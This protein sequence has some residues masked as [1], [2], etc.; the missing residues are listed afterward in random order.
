MKYVRRVASMHTKGSII[1]RRREKYY[2]V[3]A[4]LFCV[5][6][7]ND[8][9][10]WGVLNNDFE[11]DWVYALEG[12]GTDLKVFHEVTAVMLYDEYFDISIDLGQKWSSLTFSGSG[13]S[14][15]RL[16]LCR[17]VDTDATPDDKDDEIEIM[18][19]YY[20]SFDDRGKEQNSAN[21][22]TI[23]GGSWTYTWLETSE[24]RWSKYYPTS[25]F[26]AASV[27][28]GGTEYRAMVWEIDLGLTT[29]KNTYTG[30]TI[31]EPD[32]SPCSTNPC[33][34]DLEPLSIAINDDTGDIY[35]TTRHLNQA[36]PTGEG[37]VV[38]MTST[39]TFDV[40]IDGSAYVGPTC[41]Y[42]PAVC[43]EIWPDIYI[44]QDPNDPDDGPQMLAWRSDNPDAGDDTSTLIVGKTPD[45]YGNWGY[46]KEFYLDTTAHP[47]DPVTG[48]LEQRFPA[49]PKDLEGK[50]PGKGQE[51]EVTQS[52]WYGGVIGGLYEYQSDDD[53]HQYY[54]LNLLG[55]PRGPNIKIQDADSPYHPGPYPPYIYNSTPDPDRIDIGVPFT[56]QLILRGLGATPITWSVVQGP[57]GT[58][59]NSSG[60]VSGW[61]PSADQIG[62][63]TITI[64]AQ[65]TIG[66]HTESWQVRVLDYTNNGFRKEHVYM[67]R[68]YAEDGNIR[69]YWDDNEEFALAD[70]TPNDTND[71]SLTFSGTGDHDARC[72]VI[73]P[74]PQPEWPTEILIKE[75]DDGQVGDPPAPAVLNQ[76]KLGEDLLGLGANNLGYFLDDAHIRYSSYH[77]SLFIGVNPDWT[78]STPIKIYEVNLGLTTVLNT[79]TGPSITADMPDIAIDSMTGTLYVVSPNLNGSGGLGNL[80]AF[81]T[82]GGSTSTYTT[83][84]DGATL[85][86]SDWIN[87]CAIVYRGRRNPSLRPTILVIMKD[88]TASVPVLEFYLD[89]V[90]GNGNLVKRDEPLTIQGG[91]GGQVDLADGTVWLS[92]SNEVAEGNMQG[93]AMD[94][95]VIRPGPGGAKTWMDAASPPGTTICNYEGALADVD[96]DGDVDQDDFAMF[97]VCY[98]GG[99]SGGVPSEPSYCQCFDRDNDDDIDSDDFTVFQDCATGPYVPFD[100]NNPPVGCIP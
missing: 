15:A 71:M 52:V 46:L 93:L 98:T 80:I 35:I 86:D 23:V 58:Q 38:K 21:L 53:V 65:N 10:S 54:Y 37:D 85:G 17:G 14:D 3:G 60:Y 77:N 97:Q 67:V 59:V 45:S 44:W 63:Q 49:I 94:D 96:K 89:Q 36:T 61:T 87:P 84:I 9:F 27:Y 62:F 19:L 34:D 99:G 8:Q 24:I 66:S 95:S 72:F 26:V 6:L 51:D 56:R 92:G 1:M 31:P 88:T 16:F 91:S 83:L 13:S 29:L 22:S 50:F 7:V 74:S 48:N 28:V 55:F 5:L 4:C 30:P 20:D 18:E 78:S 2:L 40:I 11:T 43:A 69:I 76:A 75:Y 47:V 73:N 25:L 68:S 42:S 64:Q 39:S 32:A 33:D 81:D 57:P 12:D 41:P 70:W 79:Y 90:D 82:S 100:L